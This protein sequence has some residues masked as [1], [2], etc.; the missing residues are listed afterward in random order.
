MSVSKLRASYIIPI[1]CVIIHPVFSQQGKDTLSYQ[2]EIAVV[3][4]AFKDSIQLRWAPLNYATWK[5]ANTNGYKIERYVMVRDGK[6][7]REPERMQM[8]AL[9]LRPLPEEQWKTLVTKDKYNAI[10]AQALYGDRFEVDLSKTDIFTIV[11]KV[12]ENE[13]RFAFALF[14]ADMSPSVAKASGLWFTDKGVKENEKYLYRV[15]INT[16]ENTMGSIFIGPSDEFEL[17]PPANLIAKFEGSVA[18]LRWDNNPLAKYTAYVVE[19]STDAKIFAAISDEPLVTVSQNEL[20]DSRYEYAIDSIPD[21]SKTYYY[22]VRGLTPF[23]ELSPPSELSSGKGTITIS[24]VPYIKSGENINNAAIRLTW[25][26]GKQYNVGIKGFMVERSSKPKGKFEP[27]ST[28][29]PVPADRR[30]YDD[31]SPK[32]INYYRI[33]AMGITGE[34]YTSPVYLANL[35]D[36]IPPGPP[37]GL[38]GEINENGLVTIS[39]QPNNE[40]DIY[41][42]RVYKSNIRIEEQSQ[43]T[44]EPIIRTSFTDTVNL[45]T[46]NKEVFYSVMAIDRNQNHSKL[47]TLLSIPLPDK[48]KPQPVVFLPVTS[49]ENAVNLSWI[50]SSSP[51]VSRYF[52]YRKISDQQEWLKLSALEITQDT[53][54]RYRDITAP[55]GITSAYTVI[56]VDHSG[57]ESDPAQPVSAVKI[58]NKLKPKVIWKPARMIKD[59]A[60]VIL[61]WEYNQT[62]VV[63]FRIYKG[64]NDESMIMYRTVSG[65]KHDFTD[66]IQPEKKYK[67]RILA[68]FKNGSL[69]EFSEVLMVSF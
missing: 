4:R 3:G 55:A 1:L 20:T 46:L 59:K 5:L 40:E 39:W 23:G 56:A 50:R 25:D 14:S 11:N 26:F 16:P 30:T 62:S 38:K 53:V 7:L 41:G 17:I 2:E 65:D 47:S 37:L 15:I 12:K 31:T 51:D 33:T 27:I 66:V 22:R 24:D 64:I 45:N 44:I 6:V 35:I 60:S 29:S 67:Y 36:S 34:N 42:Y 48:I 21:L 32:N 19:R 18:S 8:N 52:V 61:N 68:M 69:S 49:D 57:L 43:V 28:Q 9:P 54:V 13:Q 63:S 10:A 58:D